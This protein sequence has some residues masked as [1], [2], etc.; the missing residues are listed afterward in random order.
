MCATVAFGAT[1]TPV[2]AA[3][4]HSRGGSQTL[5]INGAGD[6]H[7][8]G[9]SQE[10]ALGFA[11]H[12]YSYT[13]ILAHYYT[14]TVLG[15][16]TPSA[17]VRVLL[18]GNRRS[19]SFSGADSANGHAL[20]P[21]VTYTVV[22]TSHGVRLAGAG[23]R[24]AAGLLSVSGAGAVTLKGTAEN[25]LTNGSY[26]GSLSL[27]PAL[28]GGM[29]VV[30]ALSLEDYVRGT[31]AEEMPAEWPLAA[32]QA[33]AVATRT[34]A[35]TADAGPAGEF[36]VYCDTRSQMYRGVAG[37]TPRSNTATAT[38]AGQV[39]TFRGRPAI[40]YFFA[41]SG[42]RTESVQYAF[43]GSGAEPWLRGVPDP[44]DQGPLHKWTVTMSFASAQARLTGLVRGALE[45]IE[46]LKRG[47]SPRILTAYV[48]GSQGHTL[49]SGPELAARLSLNDTWA[50]FSV[51]D[52]HGSLQ[53]P[54]QSQPSASGTPAPGSEEAATAQPAASGGVGAP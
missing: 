45:G 30:N 23:V 52:S 32:L 11:Q 4:S 54:D 28:H 36:D 5:V 46:V 43:T 42:G 34:Y 22:S 14:G 41:S 38:T 21:A 48:L 12:G 39:V 29:N 20:N 27:A 51:H 44:F 31:V 25:G 8:V 50:Y 3:R 7:G 26:R 53:E 10:G 49:V 16:A 37:E 15:R 6:G 9:M 24:I 33:Q 1:C 35:I 19:A 40:T 13:A 17:N 47:Y 2:A 18:A